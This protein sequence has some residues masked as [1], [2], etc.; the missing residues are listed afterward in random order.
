MFLHAEWRASVYGDQDG[1]WRITSEISAYLFRI[2]K[3]G[4]DQFVWEIGVDDDFLVR[5]NYRGTFLTALGENICNW[6]VSDD[7]ILKLAEVGLIPKGDLVT[8]DELAR[9]WKHL[10]AQASEDWWP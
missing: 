5:S 6:S 8:A 10:F 9:S 1:K 4:W 7:H 3:Q 2:G